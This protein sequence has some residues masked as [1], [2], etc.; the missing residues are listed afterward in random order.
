MEHDPVKGDVHFFRNQCNRFKT[1]AVVKKSGH[2]DP[3]SCSVFVYKG[4]NTLRCRHKAAAHHARFLPRWQESPASGSAARLCS[5]IGRQQH[6][7]RVRNRTRRCTVKKYSFLTKRPQSAARI[8][9]ASAAHK[10]HT[11][12][13][14]SIFFAAH[15]AEENDRTFFRRASGER[16]RGFC[17]AD[18]RRVR[19]RTRRLIFQ[20]CGEIIFPPRSRSTGSGRR[21]APDPSARTPAAARARSR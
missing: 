15:V 7:R 4:C 10:F 18:K 13:L 1:R 2:D 19:N 3:M 6:K 11:C 16:L 20:I 9:C 14:R 8:I 5:P 17:Q 21:A 12:S